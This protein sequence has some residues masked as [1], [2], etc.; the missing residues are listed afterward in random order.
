MIQMEKKMK[1]KLVFAVVTAGTLLGAS[2][3]AFAQ[4]GLDNA[5]E[6]DISRYN[7]YEQGTTGSATYDEQQA[8]RG[9]YTNSRPWRG[10]DSPSRNLPQEPIVPMR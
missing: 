8:P 1:T 5:R 4:A 2:S 9:R 6:N 10:F 3:L 7:T